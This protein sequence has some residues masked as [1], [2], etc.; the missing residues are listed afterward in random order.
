MGKSVRAK[1]DKPEG[2]MEENDNNSCKSS[3]YSVKED[4]V[5]GIHE[6]VSYS[7]T[8]VDC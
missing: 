5:N 8:D 1:L 7:K 6:G 4:N 3:A 2:E